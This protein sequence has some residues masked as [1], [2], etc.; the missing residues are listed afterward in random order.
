MKNLSHGK[1]SNLRR[2]RNLDLIRRMQNGESISS[3]NSLASW[4]PPRPI[5][6]KNDEA[7]AKLYGDNVT[8]ST[9]SIVSIQDDDLTLPLR[10]A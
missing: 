2:E 1:S 3:F 9:P 8:K 5:I 6:E 7:I 4:Y 10:L